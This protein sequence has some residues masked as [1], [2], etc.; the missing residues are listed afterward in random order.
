MEEMKVNWLELQM[1]FQ[2]VAFLPIQARFYTAFLKTIIE[3]KSSDLLVGGKK[4]ILQ[5]MF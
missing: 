1:T 2:D 4:F 3:D 5:Q